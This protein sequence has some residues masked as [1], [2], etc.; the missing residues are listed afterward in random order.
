MELR[1]FADVKLHEELLLGHYV[2]DKNEVIEFSK[3]WD[4][5]P[6]HVDEEA[7]KLYPFGGLI[8]PSAYTMAVVV[9]LYNQ[10]D[11]RLAALGLTGYDEVRFPNPVRPGD[12]ITVNAQCV[13][14]RESRSKPDIGIVH[15]AVQATNQLEES[16]LT[17]QVGAFVAKRPA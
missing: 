1:Y 4:H 16:V 17:Y 14:K 15:Y 8:A 10:S 9:M 11:P 5:Q 7:A 3:K 2:V 13:N 12:I 6:F